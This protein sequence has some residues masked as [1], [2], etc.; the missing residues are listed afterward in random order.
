[1][2]GNNTHFFQLFRFSCLSSSTSKIMPLPGVV[3]PRSQAMAHAPDA[4][5]AGQLDVYGGNTTAIKLAPV[6]VA[7][8]QHLYAEPIS[9]A[10]S[11]IPNL[12]DQAMVGD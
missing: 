10:N 7:N 1:M 11:G 2:F 5:T 8:D 6:H 3:L 12:H 9:L 4:T